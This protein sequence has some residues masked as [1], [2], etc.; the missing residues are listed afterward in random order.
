MVSILKDNSTKLVNIHTNPVGPETEIEDVLNGKAFYNT[1]L[2]FKSDYSTHLDFLDNYTINDVSE[3][4]S[5]S[6]INFRS[7]EVNNIKNF[8]DEDNV[9]YNFSKKYCK[10]L[11]NGNSY[12]VPDWIVE[13]SQYFE[14]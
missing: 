10:I 8:F 6:A 9:K 1:L 2:T 13:I 12:E 5:R 14:S 4:C 3:C 7:S 11:D